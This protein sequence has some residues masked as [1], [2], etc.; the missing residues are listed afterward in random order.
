MRSILDL[1]KA[2]IKWQIGLGDDFRVLKAGGPKGTGA[3]ETLKASSIITSSGL[4]FVTAADRTLHVYDA[5][6][7]KELVGRGHAPGRRRG[8]R[9]SE[10]DRPDRPGGVRAEVREPVQPGSR[11]SSSSPA[12]NRYTPVSSIMA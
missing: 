9:G 7:G 8:R 12:A 6:N 5:D 4:V 3:A 1:N 2:T 10:P 11:R